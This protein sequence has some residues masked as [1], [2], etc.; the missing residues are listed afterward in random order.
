MRA[1]KVGDDVEEVEGGE[2]VRDAAGRPTGI[3]KDNALGKIDRAVPDATT[4]QLLGIFKC[5]AEELGDRIED[6]AGFV[7]YFGTDAVT[8][9]KDDFGVHTKASFFSAGCACAVSA[10]S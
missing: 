2:I 10:N 8:G 1:A 7:D 5:V 6:E 4:E 9:Q 3:F